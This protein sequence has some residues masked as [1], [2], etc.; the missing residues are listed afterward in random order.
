MAW[1]IGRFIVAIIV[2]PIA[3][4]IAGFPAALF[5]DIVVGADVTGGRWPLNVGNIVVACVKGLVV[6]CVA[7][8]M[9][10]GLA[11]VTGDQYVGHW[12]EQDWSDNGISH[13][14]SRTSPKSMSSA[15]RT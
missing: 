7:G 5:I 9:Q 2:A 1:A 6:G 4:E 3:G 8:S 15:C 14:F 12:L 10:Y 13:Q 11:S